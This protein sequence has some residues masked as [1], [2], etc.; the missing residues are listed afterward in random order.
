[1]KYYLRKSSDDNCFHKP[2]NQGK[3]HILHTIFFS[4]GF[5]KNR[6]PYGRQIFSANHFCIWPVLRYFAEFSAGWQQCPPLNFIYRILSE[7]FLTV[8]PGGGDEGGV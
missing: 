4:A 1:M 6:R 8:V 2:I 3:I 7:L 5:V